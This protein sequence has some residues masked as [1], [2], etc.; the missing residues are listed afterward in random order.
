MKRWTVLLSLSL[1]SLLPLRHASAAGLDDFD[2]CTDAGLA[3]L[4]AG[5]TNISMGVLLGNLIN[6]IF[7]VAVF[8]SLGFIIFGGI[9]WIT[10]AGDSGKVEA[11]RNR[12]IAA[13]VGLIII[14]LAFY[15]L[16]T[17]VLPFLGINGFQGLQITPLT[18]Y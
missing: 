16:N 9:N 5:C 10:S 2:P 15:I 4:F 1:L 8:L 6:F 14:V 17:L 11:A 7:V 3:T 18:G 13:I 12:I